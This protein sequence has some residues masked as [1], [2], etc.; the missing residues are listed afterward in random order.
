MARKSALGVRSIEALDF[1][2]R[3]TSRHTQKGRVAFHYL[4]IRPEF[5]EPQGGV[6]GRKR[7]VAARRTPQRLSRHRRCGVWCLR[8]VAVL[9]LRVGRRSFRSLPGLSREGALAG[10][11]FAVRTAHTRHCVL[12][13][14][15]RRLAFVVAAKR[16][17]DGVWR[18][19][20]CAEECCFLR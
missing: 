10:L 16:H 15:A 9:R 19:S 11:S 13:L 12:L 7:K 18:V 5:V 8:A 2:L 17:R 1:R 6:L 14:T 4:G 20:L 3:V